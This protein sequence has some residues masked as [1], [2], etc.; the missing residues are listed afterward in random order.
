VIIFTSL[1]CV[2]FPESHLLM[3]LQE[4]FRVF[5][6]SWQ[7]GT[8]ASS[9]MIQTNTKHQTQHTIFH[10][11]THISKIDLIFSQQCYYDSTILRCAPV[12]KWA[13][14]TQHL[15]HPMTQH[16]I[17]E[18][19]NLQNYGGRDKERGALSVVWITLL[20]FSSLPVT[21][22]RQ[23]RAALYV[24]IQKFN[25]LL[26]LMSYVKNLLHTPWR[27]TQ[28]H[29]VTATLILNLGSMLRWMVSLS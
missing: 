10:T 29:K 7:S 6:I 8:P 24:R 21:N 23:F 27:H 17:P 9:T 3:A 11:H 2:A 1:L 26:S 22:T 5:P 13:Q 4:H 28:G 25:L 16:H 12:V 14:S 15:S 18:D 19:L 20:C